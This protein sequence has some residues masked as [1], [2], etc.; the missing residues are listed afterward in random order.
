MTV[1]IESSGEHQREAVALDEPRVF[2]FYDPGR[3]HGELHIHEFVL[4][5]IADVDWESLLDGQRKC[6][7]DAEAETAWR[8][9]AVAHLVSTSDVGTEYFEARL[10][11]VFISLATVRSR[12]RVSAPPGRQA[13]LLDMV[14]SLPGCAAGSRGARALRPSHDNPFDWRP[15]VRGWHLRHEFAEPSSEQTRIHGH[16][17]AEFAEWCYPVRPLLNLYDE[18]I[19]AVEGYSVSGGVPLIGRE[20]IGREMDAFHKLA[21]LHALFDASRPIG[22]RGKVLP[23]RAA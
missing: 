17:D 9:F 20:R 1:E 8:D 14:W 15:S 22:E 6:C 21:A 16:K 2:R 19:E 23:W 5:R 13:V 18:L 11:S 4:G 10:R 7:S 3:D 12:Q